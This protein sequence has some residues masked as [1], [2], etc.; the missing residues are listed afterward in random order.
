MVLDFYTVSQAL[1][2]D[3]D[4]PVDLVLLWVG[5]AEAAAAEYMN[6]NIY[7]DEQSRLT[8][9]AAVPAAFTAAKVVFDS[10]ATMAASISDAEQKEMALFSSRS[11][12]AEA[13]TAAHR[14]YQGIVVNDQIR[15]AILLMVGN[16]YENNQDQALGPMVT[17]LEMNSRSLL[18]P[19]RVGM[20]I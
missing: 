16:L 7:P 17:P 3:S 19:Y 11:L 9:I 1:R 12:F 2:L 13:K 4:V 15:A 5:A 10:V 14:T 18:Q 20:G 8:A 6:R